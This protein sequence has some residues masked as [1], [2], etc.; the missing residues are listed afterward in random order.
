MNFHSIDSNV[1]SNLQK[2]IM[3]SIDQQSGTIVYHLYIFK[4]LVFLNAWYIILSEDAWVSV[5]SYKNI[6]KTM[7]TQSSV[8]LFDVLPE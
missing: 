2:N 6:I 1:P 8:E 7:F 4:T 3:L 5:S